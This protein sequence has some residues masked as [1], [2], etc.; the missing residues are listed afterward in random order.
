MPLNHHLTKGALRYQPKLKCFALSRDVPYEPRP[1]G[2]TESDPEPRPFEWDRGGERED[3]THGSCE[4]RGSE[5]Y[6]ISVLVEL[7]SILFDDSRVVPNHGYL[8]VRVSGW[9]CEEGSGSLV[10]A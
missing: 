10:V 2:S 6:R 8:Q 4:E 9:D 5:D 1:H 3:T 7:F